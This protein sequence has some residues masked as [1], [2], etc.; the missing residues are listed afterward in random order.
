PTGSVQCNV[1]QSASQIERD[2]PRA[3]LLTAQPHRV[4]A[5]AA[6]AQRRLE[7]AEFVSSY[8]PSSRDLLSYKLFYFTGEGCFHTNNSGK[9]ILQHELCPRLDF[10][11]IPHFSVAVSHREGECGIGDVIHFVTNIRS[12]AGGCLAALL[13]TY[14]GHN[15]SAD[16]M[17]D[18]PNVKSTADQCTVA[19]LV[20]DGLRVD[21]DSRNR[22]Y[23]TR[24]QRES[25]S[26]LDMENLHNR[27]ASILC[28][29]NKRLQIIDER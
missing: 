3:A 12:V 15:K 27:N 24:C 11:C 28:P 13:S 5:F 25:A 4:A 16:A 2:S 26:L 22:F 9:A 1:R 17:L 20:K 8:P 7:C 10:I 23:M 19:A 21:R 29:I 18:E 6:E 14:T